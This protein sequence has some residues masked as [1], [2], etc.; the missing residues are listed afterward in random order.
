MAPAD[1]AINAEKE[2]LRGEVEQPASD[3]FMIGKN[4]DED[5]LHGMWVT[6]ICVQGVKRVFVNRCDS[7]N[8]WEEHQQQDAIDG[9]SHHA[10]V[11]ARI[12]RA[13]LAPFWTANAHQI[14]KSKCRFQVGGFR[15]NQLRS[16]ICVVQVGDILGICTTGIVFFKNLSS[17]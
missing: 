17:V 16:G 4:L 5:A 6:R 3:K 12:M 7:I 9:S 15:H 14:C 10:A 8:D 13:A 2:Y 1:P 11:E